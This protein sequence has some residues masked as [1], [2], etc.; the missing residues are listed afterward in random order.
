MYVLVWVIGPADCN[1][2][3]RNPILFSE[4]GKRQ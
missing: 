1:R 3:K 2:C 4:S